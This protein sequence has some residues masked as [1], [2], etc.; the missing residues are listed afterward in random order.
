MEVYEFWD[1]EYLDMFRNAGIKRK[2][3]PAFAEDCDLD[4]IMETRSKPVIVSPIDRS[5][6]VITTNLDTEQ[7]TFRAINDME[8]TKIFW[9]LDDNMIGTTTSGTVFQSDVPMGEHRVRAIDEL[10]GATE[11]DFTVVK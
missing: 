9:F 6:I 5:R 4:T 3:P 1:P 8:N 7:V 11:I 10:G 2:T